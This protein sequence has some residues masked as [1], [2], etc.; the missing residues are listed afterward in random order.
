VRVATT[1]TVDEFLEL[2][3]PEDRGWELHEGELAE[4]TVPVW[5]HSAIQ[6]RL[7]KLLSGQLPNHFA[8]DEMSFRTGR[9]VRR[10]DVGV[11]TRERAQGALGAR[12]LNGAPELVVEVFSPSNKPH[13]IAAYRQL[14]FDNG[15]LAFWLVR[16][17]EK[18]V[19]VWLRDDP[20]VVTYEGSESIPLRPFAEELTVDLPSIFE[21]LI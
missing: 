12:I 1:L 18:T 13:Q 15:T 21:N 14:C 5:L 16:G 2:D 10:A 8:M 4:V 17:E 7:E 19:T 11:T 6:K 20:K 9:S 3:L